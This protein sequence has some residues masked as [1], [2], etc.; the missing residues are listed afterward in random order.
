MTGANVL[1]LWLTWACFV[2]SSGILSHVD[3]FEVVRPQR[4]QDRHRRSLQDEQLYPD[5]VKY[6]LAIEGRNLTIHLEKNRNLIGRDYTETHYLEDGKRVTTSPNEDHCFYHGRIEGMR[7]S[8]VSVGICSGISGLVRA[9]QQVYLIEPLGQSESGDHAVY[10]QEHVKINGSN[11][12]YDQD[13]GPRLAG[14]FRSRSWKTQP[15]AGPQKFVE[16]FV[17]VDN[18]EYKKYGSDTRSRILGAV[19]HIDKLYQRLNIRIML[20]G[21]EIWTYRDYINVDTNS[22]N[23][24]DNFLAWHQADLLQR[25]KHDNAQFVTGKDFDTDTVGLANKFAMCTENSAGVNQDHHDNLIGLASTIA[26]EMGHNFGMSHDTADCMCGSYRG[27]S[28]IMAAKLKTEEQAFP[29]FFSSCSKEQL[30]EFMERGQPSCLDRPSSSMKIIRVG[31][32]CGNALL[33]PGEQC[34]C[35]TVEECNNPCCDASTCRLTEGS[36][37]AQ[38]QCCDNCQLKAAGS[39]CRKSASDCDLPDYCTGV[40]EDCPEDSFEMNGK[41][42]SDQAQGYCYNGQCPTQEQHCWRLFGPGARIGSDLCFDLNKRGE[43]GANCG[44]TKSGYIPCSTLD[45]KCGTMFCGG[46]GDSITGKMAVYPMLNCKLAV[47]EDNNRNLDMVPEGTRCGTNKVCLGHKCVDTS[48]YGKKEVCSKKCNNNG[49]CNHKNECHCNPGWAPP[50]CDIQFADLSQAQSG[51][52]AGVCASV[53]ILMVIAGLIA[54]L[55]CCKK[56][57]IDNYVSKRKVHSAPGKLNPMFQEP[58]SKERPQ[59]SQPT[60][61]ESTAAQACVPHTLIVTPSRPAPQPPTKLISACPAPQTELMKPQPPSRPLP[62]LNKPQAAKP[63]P[64][65]VRPVWPSPSPAPRIKSCTPPLPP[66]KPHHPQTYIK[67]SFKFN[68]NS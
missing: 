31:P 30:A 32:S 64:P 41:P 1:S 21:L 27:E 57:N 65:A 68:Q 40:S 51:I 14:L 46:G 58:D 24:L 11:M 37:C 15:V 67:P 39:V 52:I 7:E 35:G 6:K 47:D 45:L 3:R 26:H 56:D 8:S 2:Q 50:Y 38:G 66:A 42:C 49:V 59:I 60:F 29:Q 17:V 63:N 36:Q 23:T 34:D 16:L 44:K 5:T 19:N 18:T 53:S 12:L 9:R 33:D 20:V 28:C 13:Q 54:G 4:L 48:V 55:M 43:Q 61:M 62:P 22:E 25:T 10:R